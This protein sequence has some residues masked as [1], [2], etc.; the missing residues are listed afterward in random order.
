MTVTTE[1][2]SAIICRSMKLFGRWLINL[3]ILLPV[4]SLR[5]PES[6]PRVS[7]IVVLLSAW[8][9]ANLLAEDLADNWTWRGPIPTS[10]PLYG[11]T[12]GNDLFIAVGG[13][14]GPGGIITSSDGLQWSTRA[15]PTDKSLFGVSYGDHQFVAVGEAGTI[16]TSPDGVLWTARESGSTNSLSAIC[17][18]GGTFVAVGDNGTI[19]SSADALNWQTHHPDTSHDLK[20]VTYGNGVFVSVAAY[21]TFLRSTDGIAWTLV[22]SGQEYV[23]HQ[24]TDVT[25]GNG[26]FVAAGNDAILGNAIVT[27]SD[28]IQWAETTTRCFTL[29]GIAYGGGQ[30]VAVPDYG[31]GAT[32]KDGKNWTCGS[33]IE[34][35]QSLY[36]V[37]YGLGRYVAVGNRGA[38][39]T[40]VD[41]LS[42]SN[43]QTGA[44]G[45]LFDVAWGNNTLIAVGATT[46]IYD[47]S[48]S[49]SQGILTSLNG[50]EWRQ[51][52]G[53]KYSPFLWGVTFG[54]GRFV[55]VS[56][57]ADV[58]SSQV[59][60]NGSQWQNNVLFGPQGGSS[61]TYG[62][63]VFV[64]VGSTATGI[65]EF[66]PAIATSDNGLTWKQVAVT[67]YLNGIGFGGGTFVAVG[68]QG[69]LL[70]SANA[71]NW[72]YAS[73]GTNVRLNRVGYGG[74]RFIVTGENGTIL[75][76]QDGH[77]WST[78]VSGTTNT[79]QGI[80]YG[81]DQYVVVGAKGTILAS[82]DGFTWSRK[83]S[84]THND[85]FGA[86]YARE[87]FFI[88]GNAGT[89][90]QSGTK[91]FN[92]RFHDLRLHPDGMEMHLTGELGRSFRIE[93]STNLLDWSESSVLTSAKDGV[94]YLD[95]SPPTQTFKFDRAVAP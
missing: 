2:D 75:T 73:S 95:A 22:E 93:S 81:A 78:A 1:F 69:A 89:I 76:S 21:R 36:R 64:T 25:F 87:T 59:S 20:A 52:A 4:R 86:V 24:I 43:L 13:N 7:F 91:P 77:F 62:N 9:G 5:Q 80:A 49:E 46:T 50:L 54:S 31:S 12:F 23:N 6:F 15:N 65:G 53:I 72:S 8:L 28:G 60:V 17:Y 61:V 58:G 84:G 47:S 42:W 88:V 29:H 10:N 14:E 37:A 57:W 68:W 92:L 56:Q 70:V 94:L 55:A 63:G 34:S 85:L 11:I 51:E 27:S 44:S 18:G 35:S 39:F 82:T 41:G 16:I 71:T 38:L 33:A 3:R 32:S 79:L 45:S 40:S 83:V 26:L 30:F 66:R 90:L 67:N 74:G 19:L 48:D